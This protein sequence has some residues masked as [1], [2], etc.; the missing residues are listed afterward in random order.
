MAEA[1]LKPF[2]PPDTAMPAGVPACYDP[3]A[4]SRFLPTV[5]DL[6]TKVEVVEATAATAV[7]KLAAA[8]AE[9]AELE[10]QVEQ[11]PRDRR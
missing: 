11:M 8:D 7:A 2:D 6:D 10:A 4:G 9:V 3:A 5:Y 1:I